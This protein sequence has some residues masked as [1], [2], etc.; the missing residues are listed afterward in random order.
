MSKLEEI[1]TLVRSISA[2]EFQKQLTYGN[3]LDDVHKELVFLAEKIKSKKKRTELIIEHISKCYAGDFFNFLPISDAQDELDVFCMGFN[4]YI[5]ELKAVM[6]SKNLLETINQKLITEK[7][8]SEKLALAKEEFLS[9]MSHEIRTPLNGILGFTD[10]LLNNPSLNSEGKNQLEYIKLSGGILKVIVNDILDLA[11]IESGEITLVVKPFSIFKLIQLIQDTF[12]VKMAKKNISFKISI[13]KDVPEILYGDS[14]RL[15]QILF[16]LI[17]NAV[18]FTPNHG[19]VKLS[20]KLEDEEDQWY[21]IKIMVKDTGIGIPQD[22]LE[23]IFDPFMQLD[24]VNQ[25]KQEGAG[26]GLAISKKIV[27][28][29]NGEIQVESELEIGTKFTLLVPFVKNNHDLWDAD[30]DFYENDLNIKA[31]RKRKIKVLL[32]E[33]NRINQLLAQ[34]VMSKFGFECET[35]ANGK[36]AVEAVN[37][38]DFDVILMDLMMPVMDGYEATT[39]IR[40]LEDERKKNIP[41]IALT[42]VATGSVVEVC[43][44]LGMNKY[45]AKPFNPEELRDTILALVAEKR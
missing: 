43:Q 28:Q 1:L 2:D 6:V 32:A 5:E 38:D 18:K 35:V 7:E 13:D 42:A 40:A 11:K 17:N 19:K 41:I 14:V 23:A 27:E 34:Q 29:M 21:S 33:D 26:L 22:K 24:S 20:I 15:S 45:I 12:S 31:S 39:R 16:N 3:S 36:L 9:N 37:T 44:S 8:H 30:L 10:L 4:T 25:A